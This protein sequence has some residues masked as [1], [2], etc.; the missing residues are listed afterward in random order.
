MRAVVLTLSLLAT[1]TAQAQTADVQALVRAGL[2]L[3]RDHRDEE[4]LAVFERAWSLSHGPRERA[5][6][7][8]AEQALGRWADAEAHLREA[9]SAST[10]PWVVE[11]RG[12]IEE[13]L[14]EVGAHLGELEVR[15]DAPG[16]EVRVDGRVVGT[17]PFARPVRVR[18]GRLVIEVSAPQRVAVLRDVEV[19][20]RG[21]T[22]ETVT[23]A[24]VAEPTASTPA[25]SAGQRVLAWV[26]AGGA[27]VGVGVGVGGLVLRN[28][29]AVR[30]NDDACLAGGRTRQD[31]CAIDLAEGERYGVM[32]GV[33]FGVGGALAVTSAVLF[34]T[35]PDA[36]VGGSARL[37]CGPGPG[38]VG[39]ACGG[40][41]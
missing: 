27:A 17:L 8:F 7:G 14:A 22:R 32:T 4:A 21:V 5:Q 10:D 1:G 11:R 20:A 3:R 40:T 39:L 25:G 33:G 28:D 18:A 41:L 26:L 38:T 31:N 2:D 24:P 19:R 29:A 30:W 13:A 6:M 34:L 16:A 23:L 37:A 12:V 35:L 36:R 15:G 9:L